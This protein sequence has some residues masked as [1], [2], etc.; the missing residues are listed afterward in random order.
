VPLTDA[1]AVFT[2]VNEI[3]GTRMRRFPDGETGRR[4]N[5]IN[6]QYALLAR[7]PQL[8]FAGP[9]FDPDLVVTESHGQGA[10]YAP[11]TPLRLAANVRAEE[12]AFPSLDYAHAALE[13]FASFAELKRRRTLPS[14]ARFLMAVPTPLAP[15][16]LFIDP[17]DRLAVLPA[18]AAALSREVQSVISAI[19]PRE[20]AIQ[21]DVAVEFAL[22][23]GLF[24]PPPGNWKLHL[25]D[26]LA[27]LGD[28]IPPGVELGFHLCYGDR[29]H[30]H[31][32]EPKDSANLVEVANGIAARVRRSIQWIHMPVPR[33]RSDAAFFEPLRKLALA[34]ESMLY[35][36]LVHHTDGLLGTRARIAAA[37]SVIP[38][39]GI[40][41]ECGMGRRDPNTIRDFLKLHVAASEG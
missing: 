33:A 11:P 15:I 20:L 38:K 9:K 5:W 14:D 31:F 8:E 7:H 13:S 19:A 41:A 4:R 16:A 21:W 26:Q 36:G 18:Y 12:L 39:F 1:T 34:P 10:D 23:E 6:F 24:P 2:V 37:T 35:L 27:A 17:R 3:L 25:L 40:A 28:S 22:W 30:R 32:T 29:G